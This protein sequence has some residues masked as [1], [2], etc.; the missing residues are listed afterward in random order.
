MAG[1][2]AM[3]AACCWG[4]PCRAW[5]GAG[6]Y[7]EREPAPDL[8]SGHN[9]HHLGCHEAEEHWPAREVACSRPRK[10]GLGEEPNESD[11]IR[12]VNYL[13]VHQP[14]P[15]AE[16]MGCIGACPD[17][18][19]RRHPAWRQLRAGECTPSM[20]GTWPPP[21]T[22]AD[23]QQRRRLCSTDETPGILGQSGSRHRVVPSW[24]PSS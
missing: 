5:G 22:G 6:T 17:E 13:A 16:R 3:T 9:R 7:P 21:S 18:S 8:V 19:C 24:A 23:W 11:D 15:E 20:P 2:M 12:V 14:V 10:A 1:G 4:T